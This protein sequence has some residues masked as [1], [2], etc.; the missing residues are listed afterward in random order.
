MISRYKCNYLTFVELRSLNDCDPELFAQSININEAF[1]MSVAVGNHAFSK[2]EG[3]IDGPRKAKKRTP[4]INIE[5]A[6]QE[7]ARR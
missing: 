4:A 3:D 2:M 7:Q 5:A 1:N 6:R